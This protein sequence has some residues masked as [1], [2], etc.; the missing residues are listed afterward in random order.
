[1]LTWKTVLL[2]IANR[3]QPVRGVEIAE[4]FDRTTGEM[5][6]RLARLRQWGYLNFADGRR[7]ASGR[8]SRTYEITTRG[9]AK[10]EELRKGGELS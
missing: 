7:G 9:W 6:S 2:E 5:Y 4:C 8:A 1:M 3:E 10:V